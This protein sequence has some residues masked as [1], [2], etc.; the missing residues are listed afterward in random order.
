M[1]YRIKIGDAVY[2]CKN[3]E[4]PG[5]VINIDDGLFATVV[6]QEKVRLYASIKTLRKDIECYKGNLFKSVE[7]ARARKRFT[8]S[9][10]FLK[11]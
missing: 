10:K 6:F 3:P 1:A 9:M 5:V 4:V 7:E 8:N 2:H 11:E